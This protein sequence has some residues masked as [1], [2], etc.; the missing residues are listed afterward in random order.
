MGIENSPEDRKELAGAMKVLTESFP[1]EVCEPEVA[2]G[3]ERIVVVPAAL[4]R[5]MEFLKND[6][7]TLFDVLVDITAVDY[8]GREPRFEVVY[9]LLSYS[10]HHRIRIKVRV[11]GMKPAVPSICAFWGSANW[12]EREVWDMFGIEFV[13]HPELKRILLYP[14]FEGHP[15]RKD[16]PVRK[17]QPLVGPKN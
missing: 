5:V 15:L 4:P 1:G 6:P 11:P 17:R 12:L 16:Y 9:H 14:E 8:A 3:D 10:F 2:C 13:G 7:R